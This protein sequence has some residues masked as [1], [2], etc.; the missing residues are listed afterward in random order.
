MAIRVS[1]LPQ[2]VMAILAI[3]GLLLGTLWVVRPFLGPGIW[4]VT[5]VVAT[6]PLFRRL[7]ARLGGRRAPAVAVMALI[8]LL[9]IVV[10]VWLAVDTVIEQSDRL[11]SLARALPTLQIPPPPAWV[12]SLPLGP[13]IARFWTELSQADPGALSARIEPY[14]GSVVRWF[15]AQA[16]SFG[17]LL[18]HFLVMLII[19]IV[20]F[21]KGDVAARGVLLFF[22]RLAGQQGEASVV[23]AGQAIRA[24][25]LG[26]I[27]TALVQSAVSGIGLAIAGIPRAGLLTA[28]VFLLC[29]AQV[30]PFL[31]MVPAVVWLYWSGSPGWGTFLLVWTLVVL[32]MDNVLRPW[33]ITR[34]ANLP[35]LL[36]FAGVIGGLLSFGVIGL[37]IGPVI[38]A[39]SYTLLEAWVAEG[40]PAATAPPSP[41]AAPAASAPP[42]AA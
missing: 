40:E 15:G 35:I 13:R 32:T 8:L 41:A 19:S 30:G 22:R 16:G 24:V 2:T 37:F 42:P 34:G 29:I 27:V 12:Q 9:I 20:L 23:L 1:N 33:L 10:P 14:V 31:V 4:S 26:V 6:W 21:A 17:T 3:S 5:I 18:V 38:L 25:A 11:I 7:Q 36:I 39:V 28:V